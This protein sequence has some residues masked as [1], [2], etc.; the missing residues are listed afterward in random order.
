LRGRWKNVGDYRVYGQLVVTDWICGAWEGCELRM[1]LGCLTEAAGTR[2]VYS[3]FTDLV[4]ERRKS[5]F[6]WER[7]QVPF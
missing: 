4:T 1:T 3:P 5:G 2:T 7:R 6:W